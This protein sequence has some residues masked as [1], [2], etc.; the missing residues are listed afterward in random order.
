MIDCAQATLPYL[1]LSI[2]LYQLL[3]S[4]EPQQSWD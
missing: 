1:A 2:T 4:T 3:Y